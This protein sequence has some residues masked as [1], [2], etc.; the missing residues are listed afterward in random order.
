[1]KD[2][3]DAMASSDDFG[4]RERAEALKGHLNDAAEELREADRQIRGFV[5]ESPILA[6]ALAVAGGYLIG[7]TFSQ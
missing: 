1:M 5:K 4:A 3:E 6:L 2:E 7:R